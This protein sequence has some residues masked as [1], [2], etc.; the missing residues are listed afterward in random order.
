MWCVAAAAA[1]RAKPDRRRKKNKYRVYEAV[2]CSAQAK[3]ARGRG[4]TFLFLSLPPSEKLFGKRR[5]I[6]FNNAPPPPPSHSSFGQKHDENLL[7]TTAR[8]HSRAV[9]THTHE[10]HE[11]HLENIKTKERERER[12][13]STGTGYIHS[14]LYPRVI[15]SFCSKNKK[16]RNKNIVE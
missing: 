9:H 16:K 11:F 5:R 13:K 10:K 4:P 8:C 3:A 1:H 7:D 2:R 12:E 15:R 6:F 14:A